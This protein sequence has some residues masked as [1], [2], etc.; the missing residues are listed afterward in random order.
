MSDEKGG[1]VKPEILP[2]Y[3]WDEKV[4]SCLKG[5]YREASILMWLGF[6]VY[7]GG[8]ACIL[9]AMHRNPTL[10]TAVVMFFFQLLVIFFG[11][12]KLYPCISGAFR[13]GLLANRDSIPT[14]D[15]LGKVV[16]KVEVKLDDPA[17]DF[18]AE[19]GK[20][21]DELTEIRKALTKPVSQ[22]MQKIGRLAATECVEAKGAGKTDGNGQ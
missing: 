14:F 11:T 8:S 18:R 16:D 4:D 9:W 17:L 2:A 6:I 3:T 22:P 5:V 20:I 10:A 13:V 7:G 15:R 1:I 21:R 12:R 19:A